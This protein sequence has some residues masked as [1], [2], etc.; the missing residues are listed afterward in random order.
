MLQTLW[1]QWVAGKVSTFDLLTL[2]RSWKAVLEL[3]DELE[4]GLTA[5]LTLRLRRFHW[6]DERL[7]WRT[8]KVRV[9][10][11]K[12][13]DAVPVDPDGF[14]LKA[15]QPKSRELRSRSRHMVL[16][17]ASLRLDVLRARLEARR[18]PDIAEHEALGF[19]F[20][21]KLT[22]SFGN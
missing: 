17:D 11:S 9:E 10:G 19:V 21:S 5:K 14:V 3:H 16:L 15:K 2:R 18:T 13:A 4:I 12:N 1:A 7:L 8:H 20:Y 6:S 22:H